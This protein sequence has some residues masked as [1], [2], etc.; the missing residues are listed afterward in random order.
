MSSSLYAG[1]RS[2]GS[3]LPETK[4]DLD[5]ATLMLALL[6][7]I[8]RARPVQSVRSPDPRR[9]VHTNA[10]D[11]H[12]Q[13]EWIGRAHRGVR[14][15]FDGWDVENRSGWWGRWRWSCE[16]R[17]RDNVGGGVPS[18]RR[19]NVDSDA[20]KKTGHEREAIP[21]AS[22]IPLSGPR[23]NMYK[24]ATEMCKRAATTGVPDERE[25]EDRRRSKIICLPGTRRVCSSMAVDQ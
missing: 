10:F 12:R 14:W 24:V 4:P 3:P 8:S 23:A 9:S 2:N 6:A 11:W 19:E 15:R 13:R 21:N 25:L 18:R 20:G 17:L 16:T 22:R 5:G 1:C 7:L